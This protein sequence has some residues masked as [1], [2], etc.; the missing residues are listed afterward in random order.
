MNPNLPTQLSVRALFAVGSDEHVLTAW[1]LAMRAEGH[2]EKTVELRCGAA[3]V[4]ARMAGRPLRQLSVE[5]WREFLASYPNPSTKATYHAAAVRLCRFMVAE[6]LRPDDPT[7][8]IKPPRVPRG[9]PRPCTTTALAEM[10]TAAGAHRPM[11]MLA[12]YQGLRAAEVAKV[13]GDDV[14]PG[15][16][17]LHVVGKGGVAA[18]LPMHPEIAALARE[19]PRLGWWFP[20]PKR[21]GEPVHAHTVTMAVRRACARAGLPEMGAHRLRHW[22]GT[23]LVNSGTDLRT[24]QTLLRHSSLTT[25]ATYVQVNDE[26]RRAAVLRLP[27]LGGDRP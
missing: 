11:L 20:S 2:S 10:L 27:T 7:E 14:D 21:A 19:M 18:N 5:D 12:A 22:Y 8:R 23:E 24:A 3:R 9:V 26:A 13:R 6:G 17:V 15:R 16:N 1:S 25:T 4:A